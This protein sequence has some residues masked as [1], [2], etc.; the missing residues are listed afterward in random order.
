V[1]KGSCPI[2]ASVKPAATTRFDAGRATQCA[3]VRDRNLYCYKEQPW[4][5]EAGNSDEYYGKFGSEQTWLHGDVDVGETHT[6]TYR[7]TIA[8]ASRWR[9]T[10]RT[11]TLTTTMSALTR[12]ASATSQKPSGSRIFVGAENE[13]V[14]LRLTHTNPSIPFVGGLDELAIYRRALSADEVRDLYRGVDR[15]L[16]IRFDEAPGRDTFYDH[17]GNNFNG[18]CDYA[19]GKCPDSGLP[20]G[21]ARPPLRWAGRLRGRDHR[22][23]GDRLYPLAVVQDYLRR[24]WHLFGGRRHAGH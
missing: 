23:A 19:A 15:R 8:T 24:L 13:S 1:D 16:E 10:R 21:P 9:F 3:T 18:V 6:T 4:P 12:L 11:K 17:S 22:R 14:S 7:G 5:S 20:G 2:G